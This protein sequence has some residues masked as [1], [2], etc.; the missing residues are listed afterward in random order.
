MLYVS[1]VSPEI[2]TCNLEDRRGAAKT[3]TGRNLAA[4]WL[5][6][7]SYSAGVDATASL[8]LSARDSCR[9]CLIRQVLPKK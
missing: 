7:S 5:A 6:D 3:A 2:C 1:L 9:I 8:L 4:Q